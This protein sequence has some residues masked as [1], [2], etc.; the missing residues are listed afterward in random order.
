MGSGQILVGH[1]VESPLLGC[2]SH[3]RNERGMRDAD[4]SMKDSWEHL[5]STKFGFHIIPI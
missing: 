4:G 2:G 3:P 5:H 1:M